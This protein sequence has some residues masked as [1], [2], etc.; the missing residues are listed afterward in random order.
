MPFPATVY[1]RFHEEDE[2]VIA[3]IIVT[4]TSPNPIP[5]PS[6]EPNWQQKKKLT[7]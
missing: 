2:I 6:S 7:H 5:N 3:E 4:N 1:F